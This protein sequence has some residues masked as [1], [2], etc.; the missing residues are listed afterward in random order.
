MTPEQSNQPLILYNHPNLLSLLKKRW[1]ST[2]RKRTTRNS[3]DLI[4]FNNW[5]LLQRFFFT[6]LGKWRLHEPHA[7]NIQV[8][9]SK[10]PPSVFYLSGL[11]CRSSA[12]TWIENHSIWYVAFLEITTQHIHRLFFKT[13]HGSP[14]LLCFLRLNHGCSVWQSWNDPNYVGNACIVGPEFKRYWMFHGV[15]DEFRIGSGTQ[16]K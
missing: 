14:S 1:S 3:N 11:C 7:F 6:H 8:A 2:S 13:L 16:E 5:F 12:D 4:H 10:F 9:G 15:H